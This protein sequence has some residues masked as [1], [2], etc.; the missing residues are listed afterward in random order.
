MVEVGVLA[1][2]VFELVPAIEGFVEADFGLSD[3]VADASRKVG[4]FGRDE[5]VWAERLS[6]GEQQDFSVQRET[7]GD[8]PGVAALGVRGGEQFHLAGVRVGGNAGV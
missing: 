3:R 4:T 5:G 7:L 2:R 8:G 1:G 6:G